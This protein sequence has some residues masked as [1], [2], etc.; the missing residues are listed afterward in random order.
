[1][2]ELARAL[3][4]DPC[5]PVAQYH[6]AWMRE[7]SGRRHAALAHSSAARESEPNLIGARIHRAAIRAQEGTWEGRSSI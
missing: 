6:L 2:E 7:D 4:S 5:P 1:M 3:P